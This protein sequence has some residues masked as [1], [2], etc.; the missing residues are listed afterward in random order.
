MPLH[1]L[2]LELLT[3]LSKIRHIGG[4][5]VFASDEGAP[6]SIAKPWATV[7]RKAEIA[8]FRFHDLRHTAASYMAMNGATTI[9]IAAILGHKTLQMVKR[10]SHLA[11]SHASTVVESMNTK[12]FGGLS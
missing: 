9:D 6:V 8:N 4:N 1:G 11:D 7:L 5:A 12:I 10:Y 3:D 2:A